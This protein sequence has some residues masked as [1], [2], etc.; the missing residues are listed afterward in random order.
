[1]NK[2]NKNSIIVIENISWKISHTDMKIFSSHLEP[3]WK[4]VKVDCQ[5]VSKLLRGFGLKLYL[6]PKSCIPNVPVCDEVKEIKREKI[7]VGWMDC[8][9]LVEGAWVDGWI[10]S[11]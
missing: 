6:P 10:Y 5:K 11:P 9:W 7:D 4:T 1:M 3:T 8:Q 2:M